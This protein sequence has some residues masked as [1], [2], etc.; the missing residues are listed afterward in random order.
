MIP[1]VLRHRLHGLARALVGIGLLGCAAPSPASSAERAQGSAPYVL[2]LGTAQDG[3][4]P[5][6]GC[7]ARCCAAA[8]ADPARRRLVTSLLLCDPRD[9]RRWLFDCTPDLGEQLERARGHPPARAL[10]DPRPPLFEGLFLTHAHMGHYGGLLQLGREAYAAREVPTF[11]TPRMAGF[12]ARNGP[13]SLLVEERVLV[14]RELLEGAPV[15]LAPELSVVAFRVPHRDELSDTVGFEIR[16][17]TLTLAY[18]PDIDKWE[19]WD[20]PPGDAAPARRIEEL[21]ARCDFAL[22]DGS[23]FADGEIPGRGMQDIPHPFIAESIA[24]FAALPPAERAKVFFT[25]LNHSNP[26]AEERSAARRAI[27][28]A[29][30]QVLGEGRVF[31]L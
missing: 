1:G 15:E 17:P 11:V 29:G 31:G 22:L 2:V 19:R 23:F 26:A 30:M 27:L 10:A 24:R 16:G 6:I 3:G 28:A 25:H 4:L 20:A 8:R 21:I 12:L 9:G 5:H 14:L 13:W 18:L 7:E